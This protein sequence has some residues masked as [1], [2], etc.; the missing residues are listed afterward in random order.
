MI[1]PA[2]R[3]NAASRVDAATP[4]TAMIATVMLPPEAVAVRGAVVG[5]VVGPAAGRIM[6]TLSVWAKFGMT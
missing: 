5:L 1:A 4:P 2:F 6:R 3:D